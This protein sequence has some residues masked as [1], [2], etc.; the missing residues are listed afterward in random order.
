MG[1]NLQ[2]HENDVKLY[3]GKTWISSTSLMVNLRDLEV[4]RNVFGIPL[5]IIFHLEPPGK[6]F[7]F[8]IDKKDWSSI[9]SDSFAPFYTRN[10]W[11]YT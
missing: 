5:P 8:I 10:I 6:M 9:K 11:K 7:F 2:T 4:N 1:Y 3:L